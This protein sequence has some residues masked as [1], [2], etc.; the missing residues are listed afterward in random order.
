MSSII[1]FLNLNGGTYPQIATRSSENKLSMHD[2]DTMVIGGVVKEEDIKN[3]QRMPL[4]SNIPFFGELFKSR[5]IEKRKSQLI[6][7]ITPNI[8]KQ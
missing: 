4:L 5:R 2:G 7:S 1:E 3:Y 6:I 8:I